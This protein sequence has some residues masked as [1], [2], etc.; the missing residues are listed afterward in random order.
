MTSGLLLCALLAV[1]SAAAASISTEA[2]K[3]SLTHQKNI[4]RL[5][6][7]IQQPVF[8]PDHDEIIKTFKW[9]SMKD[10]FKDPLLLERFMYWYEH[11]VFLERNKDFSLTFTT[12]F[13]QM[14]Q[15][16]RVL[17]SASDFDTFYKMA[18]WMRYHMNE[19]MFAYVLYTVLQHREDTQ[20]MMVPPPYEVFPQYFVTSDVMQMA[21]D[22]H[23]RGMTSKEDDPY[24]IPANYTGWME[25]RDRESALS[26]FRED[27]GLASYWAF[28]CYKYPFWISHTDSPHK[29]MKYRGRL[30]YV[31]LRNMLA[32][33]DM[34][35][36]ARGLPPVRPV[37]MWEPVE[38][39]DPEIRHQSGHEFPARPEGL[40]A[41]STDALPMDNLIDWEGRI[42][43]G[44][45]MSIYLDEK[46]KVQQ[47]ND[48][49][50]MNMIGYIL[51]GGEDSP[52]TKY[53]GS[54]FYGLFAIFGHMMD[55]Y[56]QYGM[57]PSVLDIPETMTRDPLFYRIMK[58]MWNIFDG[59]KD[60]QLP[61]HKDDLIVPGLK[62]ESMKIDKLLTYFDD[63]DIHIDNAIDV[64]KM[65]DMR[66]VNVIARRHRMNHKPFSYSMKVTSDKEMKAV[67]RVFMGPD[68]DW[69]KMWTGDGMRHHFY[70]LDAFHT[71]LKAGENTIVRN[72]RDMFT[73]GEE[74]PGY[75]QMYQMVNKAMDEGKMPVAKD[76]LKYEGFPHRLLLPHGWRTGLPVTLFAIVTDSKDEMWEGQTITDGRDPFFPMDRR[77]FMWELKTIPNAHF[78][79]LQIFHRSL[80][81]LNVSEE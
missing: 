49:N 16:F 62:I 53:Y 56:H 38:G 42:R 29:M 10:K 15:M 6:F 81:E 20:Y 46:V 3:D 64:Q 33:Y 2:N 44:V 69:N 60:T 63:F 79:H 35:R 1:A 18:V 59:Y 36:Y 43:A 23:L 74:A 73:V 4:M 21:Y 47:L 80:K 61:Y 11:G 25:A 14:K 31:T 52:N 37:D 55:P 8:M 12:H 32:R 76:G 34:E 5:F 28:F 77:V 26:Y 75:W 45:A 50:A 54:V 30:F 41:K 58:R 65:D 7:K 68:S 19:R 66:K 57:A 13:W 17:H 78:E 39:Y 22:A 9:E 72:S 67:V 71:Q 40:T 27:V 70:L 24:V 48:E 51:R